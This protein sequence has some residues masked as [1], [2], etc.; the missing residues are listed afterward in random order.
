MARKFTWDS[1][2]FDCDGDAYIVAKD[3]C[4]NRED[5]PGYIV[6][7]DKLHQDCARGMEIK[8]GWCKFQVRSDWDGVDGPAGCYVVETYE[9]YTKKL[10]GKRKSGWFPVWI[11]RKG[12][13]Y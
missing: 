11:V 9:P 5:V 4:S 12:E 7:A 8:E 13:W 1:W 6:K 2:D 3:E 10:N